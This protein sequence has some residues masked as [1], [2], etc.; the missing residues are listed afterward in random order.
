[1]IARCLACV[2]VVAAALLLG[3]P[4]RAMATDVGTAV[5]APASAWD[6]T[7]GWVG[8]DPTNGISV[9]EAYVRVAVGHAYI[10]AAPVRGARRGGGD[11]TMEVSVSAIDVASGQSQSQSQ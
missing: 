11:E 10:A 3:L 9:T 5:Q 7:L 4:V 2:A 6:D 1:M 8:F